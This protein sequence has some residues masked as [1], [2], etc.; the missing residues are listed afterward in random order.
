[1]IFEEM[2][3]PGA[4]LVKVEKYEDTRGFFARA[5]CQHEFEAN[6]LSYQLTQMNISHNRARH[7]LRG[8]H[9][10]TVPHQEDKL[11]RCTRGAVH[12]IL[13]DLRFGSPTYK[14]HVAAVLSRANCDMLLVPKGCASAFVTLEDDT[15]VIYLLS[16]PYA[17][18]SARGVRWNDPAFAFNWP[19][20]RP[21][22]ISE[23]DESWP[24]FT[25]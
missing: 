25:G 9:F 3:I 14:R 7:T 12:N 22:V 11:I 2:E 8:F 21:A 18:L 1:V 20:P 23:R 16:E 13:L 24:D 17:P 19:V 4:Y 5:W 6:G 15:D 10:Q